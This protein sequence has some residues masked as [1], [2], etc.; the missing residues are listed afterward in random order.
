[1]N[2]SSVII[3]EL[4]SGLISRPQKVV[5]TL[6]HEAD[7][8]GDEMAKDH[9][10]GSSASILTMSRSRYRRNIL[11]LI[12]LVLVAIYWHQ[13]SSTLWFRVPNQASCAFTP[14]RSRD[15]Q[16]ALNPEDIPWSQ[17]QPSRTLAYRDCFGDLKCARLLLPLDWNRT[18]GDGPEVA[19]AVIKRP[20]RVNVTDSRYGGAII[21]NPGGPAGSGVQKLLQAGERIQII[22]DANYPQDFHNQ[23]T[24]SEDK[25]FDIISFDPRGVNHST[26]QLN[27]FPDSFNRFI[28]RLQADAEGLIGSSSTAFD[29]KWARYL[30]RS[31]T[32]M[33]LIAEQGNDSIAYYMGTRSVVNDLI[34]I[35]ERHGEWREAE[36][37]LLFSRNLAA[38]DVQEQQRVLERTKWLRGQEEVLYWGTSYGTV[39]GSTLAALYPER[40][41]RAILDSVVAPQSFFNVSQEE[42]L[43]DSDEVLVK[44]AFLCHKHGPQ[45][46]SFYRDSPETI[47]RDIE[48]ISSGLTSTPLAVPA[49]S[50]RGPETITSSDLKRLI[51]QCLYDPRSSF[52][53]LGRLLQDLSTE[54]GASF[55]DYKAAL[56]EIS[57]PDIQNGIYNLSARCKSDGP[58]TPAC[59]RPNEWHEE[60]LLGISCGDGRMGYN[61]TKEGFKAYW[62]LLRDQSKASADVWAEWDLMCVGWKAESKWKYE[63]PFSGNTAHPILFVGNTLDPVCPLRSAH[64]VS[65]GFTGSVVLEQKTIGHGILSAKSKCTEEAIKGYFQ[66]GELP[67]PGSACEV[68]QEPFQEAADTAKIE[69]MSS[70]VT[71]RPW[72]PHPEG[73]IAR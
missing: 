26:P 60:S 5:N 24:N 25:F 34:A 58:Y 61:I 72:T 59:H 13:L 53:V 2:S 62:S 47:L 23:V 37:Q 4:R 29:Q 9:G 40:V 15:D 3:L 11:L 1:M 19:V 35:A 31:E 46:C 22:V 28:W 6:M 52:P 68:E 12:L 42:S 41:R 57:I 16:L 10:N 69:I 73:K 70:Q 63:G 17:I 18:K 55:A 39:L 14:S 30:S 7:W 27:C 54:D 45:S 48:S 21:L 66:R 33:K 44:F 49:S 50:Y 8:G 64:K 20:A 71:L 67:A 65:A 36:A 51:G 32:C 56:K 38:F 43:V